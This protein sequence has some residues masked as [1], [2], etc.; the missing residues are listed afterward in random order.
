MPEDISTGFR[1]NWGGK[2][3]SNAARDFLGAAG[4]EG[5]D[6][7][8][9][10]GEAFFNAVDRAGPLLGAAAISKGIQKITGDSLSNDD[11]FG[12]ISGAIINPNV[13]LLY[14]STDLR[15]FSLRFKLVPR[16]DEETIDIN[17]ILNQF[18]K[19][20]LPKSVPG[21]VFG[22]QNPGIIGGFIG[23]PTLCRVSFMKG[24]RENKFLPR[25]KMCAITQ[26]DANYTPDGAYATYRD[27]QPVAIDLSISFQETKLIF[28]EDI[29]QGIR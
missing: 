10:T 2:A 20:M 11:V 5:L 17:L 25:Y 24:A 15:N 22:G 27:G 9:G 1:S 18:K 19:A 16:N 3:L 13:E 23:V 8:K 21:N 26:V 14:Q 29:E 28:A 12:A 7:L 6:K 4:A